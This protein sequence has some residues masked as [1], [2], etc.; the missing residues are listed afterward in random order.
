MKQQGDS[1]C[2]RNPKHGF[3]QS[4]RDR[5]LDFCVVFG[6]DVGT[7]STRDPR[8]PHLS[9]SRHFYPAECRDF[10]SRREGLLLPF[11]PIIA[12]RLHQEVGREYGEADV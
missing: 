1:V 12:D 10:T 3:H 11:S 4:G 9:R 7:F 5:Q 2:I 6:F 8:V